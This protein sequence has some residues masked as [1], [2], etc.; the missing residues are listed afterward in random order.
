[1]ARKLD[2]FLQRRREHCEKTIAAIEATIEGR[3]TVDLE[4]TEVASTDGSKR[5]ITKIPV[6][7]LIKIRQ[8]YLSELESIRAA[9]GVSPG[10]RRNVLVRF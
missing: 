6:A 2:E 4:H 3:I 5:V 1:M 10:G 7:E 9:E 8:K